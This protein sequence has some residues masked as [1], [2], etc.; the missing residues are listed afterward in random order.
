MAGTTLAQGSSVTLTVVA[1]DSLLIDGARSASAIVEAV[2]GVAGSA[3]RQIIAKHPGG[4]AVYGPFGAGTV[5]L[6]AVGG[7]I[8]YMQGS[9]PLVDEGGA[10]TYLTDKTGNAIALNGPKG[11]I[12][13]DGG[14]YPVSG[15]QITSPSKA[16]FNFGSQANTLGLTNCTEAFSTTYT[17]FHSYTRAI[18]VTDNVTSSVAKGSQS[19][20][21]DT[22]DQL[23]QL[24]FYL[25]FAPTTGQ[26]ITVT[27][28]NASSFTANNVAFSFD[29]SYLKMGWNSC[30][31]WGG[32][33]AG[34]AGVGTLAVGM[35]KTV[36]GT[37]FDW[38]STIGR[39]DI[40]FVGMN[41]LVVYL[42][43]FRRGC[44]TFPCLVMGFDATGTGAADN[45]MTEKVAPL[46]ATAGQTGYFTVTYI[47]DMVSAGNADY[48]RKHTLYN[49]WGWDA[50]NHTWNHG[51]TK[52]GATATVTL[53]RTSNVVTA[54]WSAAHGYTVSEK[55]YAYVSGATPSDMNGLFEVT[56][57][58]TTAATYTAAGA[59]GSGTGTIQL[60]TIVERVCLTNDSTTQALL[61]HEIKD[62]ARYIKAEGWQRAAHIGAWPNNSVPHYDLNTNICQ[63]AGIRVFRG[64]NGGTQ[65]FNEAQGLVNPLHVGSVEMGS[66]STATTLQYVKDKLTGAIGR[67]ESLWTY[68]HYILD[69]TDPANA[70][71]LPVD[72]GLSPGQGSNPNPPSASLQGGFGGWWYFSQLKRFIDEAV[73]P[74]VNAG[75]LKVMTPSQWAAFHGIF[76][77]YA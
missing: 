3:N 61:R 29:A 71:Y 36:N 35:S 20:Q 11:A 51:I 48:Y 45:T 27:L 70:A 44:K 10:A 60:S 34:A 68:G 67:G 26:Y 64:A 56:P 13:I 41:G 9:A 66:G 46:L 74:A 43:S 76:K 65:V 2:S 8:A 37:G 54:T 19:L 39:F 4:Q 52:P 5:K 24:D 73:I 40:N 50:L 15:A 21:M 32:D 7:D 77:E 53:S 63:E 38:T 16:L 12:P 75:T 1:T 57:T 30:R 6:A 62:I 17:N 18:T 69:D 42:D 49:T 47:Y 25:P 58:T 22:T 72:N 33:A 55:F 59:N 23:L 14:K 28:N 31:M